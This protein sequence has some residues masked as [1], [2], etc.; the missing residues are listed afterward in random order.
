MMVPAARWERKRFCSR[1][2]LGVENAKRV[3]EIRRPP[4]SYADKL[5]AAN[6][7]KR[8]GRDNERWVEPVV[9][10]CDFCGGTYERKPNRAHRPSK[11]RYCSRQCRNEHRRTQLSG[12]G[13][14]D[15]VGGP[16]TYR[17]RGWRDARMVIVERQRGCCADCGR[18]VGKSLP[19]HHIRPFRDFVS[20]EEANA[21]RNLIGLCQSCHMRHEYRRD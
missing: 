9:L 20:A 10:T 2:C 8:T 1:Q 11:Y 5:R 4:K 6:L 13:A 3:N 18:H 12:E 21:P 15:W 17:G 14:P 7:G 19:V 16:K